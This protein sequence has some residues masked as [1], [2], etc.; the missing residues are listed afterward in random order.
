MSQVETDKRRWSR[1]K[2]SW[3]EWR[4][5]LPTLKRWEDLPE[6]SRLAMYKLVARTEVNENVSD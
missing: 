5:D 4:R 6:R 1:A 3:L 2:R